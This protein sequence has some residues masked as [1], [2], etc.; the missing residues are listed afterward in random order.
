VTL[1]SLDPSSSVLRACRVSAGLLVFLENPERLEKQVRKDR[2]E[3]KVLMVSRV[4][5]GS[6]VSRVL[7][8]FKVFK[9]SAACKVTKV[10]K[11]WKVQR[12]RLE[13][14][15]RKVSRVRGELTARTVLTESVVIPASPVPSGQLGCAVR[16]VRRVTLVCRDHKVFQESFLS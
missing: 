10:N 12:A 1:E 16:M 14:L 11:A 15:A 4:Q 7:M 8:V 13:Q 2:E 6:V 9:V 3:N 5:K